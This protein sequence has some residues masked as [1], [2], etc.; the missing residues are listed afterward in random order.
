M[1]FFDCFSMRYYSVLSCGVDSEWK[2]S[3]VQFLIPVHGE[4]LHTDVTRWVKPAL[5][6]PQL[7]YP[8]TAHDADPT[9]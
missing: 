3:D 7:F 6:H 1:V 4:L 8:G 5:A 9:V 2:I